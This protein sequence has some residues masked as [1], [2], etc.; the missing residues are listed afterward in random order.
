M[1]IVI[2]AENSI[3]TNGKNCV[4]FVDSHRD[5]RM[6]FLTIIQAFKT[7]NNDTIDSLLNYSYFRIYSLINIIVLFLFFFKIF[8]HYIASLFI[9]IKEVI[10]ILLFFTKLSADFE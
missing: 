9:M 1:G 10:S 5:I 7:R 2:H 4:K 3:H 6:L 8:I